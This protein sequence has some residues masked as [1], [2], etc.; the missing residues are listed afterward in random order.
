MSLLSHWR[1]EMAD[2]FKP[3]SRQQLAKFLPND[4]AIRVFEQLFRQSGQLV[5]ES[6]TALQV[7]IEEN[8]DVVA[9]VFAK[10]NAMSEQIKGLAESMPTDE[11]S[12]IALL[13][14]QMQELTKQVENM[15]EIGPL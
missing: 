5:P 11:L 4:E 1:T 8:S 7:S 14:A 13:E 10:T 15:K 2:N 12:R 6:L 9:V 3:L